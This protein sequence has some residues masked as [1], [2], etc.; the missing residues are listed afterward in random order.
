MSY[1]EPAPIPDKENPFESMMK[2]FDKAAE[3][4]QLEPGVYSN[5]LLSYICIYM[6]TASIAFL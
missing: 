6:H 5:L 1:K 3:I 2:R 4:L